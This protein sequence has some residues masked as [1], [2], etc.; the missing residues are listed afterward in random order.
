MYYLTNRGAERKKS[1]SRSGVDRPHLFV[2]ILLPLS[3]FAVQAPGSRRDKSSCKVVFPEQ[4]L[5]ERLTAQQYHVTQEKGTESAFTGVYTL[6]KDKGTYSCVVCG[7]PLFT[8]AT[9]FDSGSAFG[10]CEQDKEQNHRSDVVFTRK[11]CT[12][13]HSLKPHL[14]QPWIHSSSKQ[15]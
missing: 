6:H 1:M 2:I 4:E 13:L 7:T 8:S 9:K 10:F 14:D 15:S 5:R 11:R 3:L 12:Q